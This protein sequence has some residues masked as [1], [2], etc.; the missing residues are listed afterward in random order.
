MIDGEDEPIEVPWNSKDWEQAIFQRRDIAIIG[1][2]RENVLYTPSRLV[3]DTRA[4]EDRRVSA[5]LERRSA[6][7]CRE[8]AAEVA[9]RLGLT[10]LTISDEEI[11]DAVRAIRRLAPGQASLDHIWLPGPNRV[12]GDDLPVPTDPVEIPGPDPS[13]GK[14]LSIFVLDTGIAPKVPFAVDARPED[15]EIPDE[16]GDNLRDFAAG[17]GTHISGLVAR[18]APAA[19]IAPRRLLTSPVGMASELDTAAAILAAG[20]DGADIINCSFGGTTLFDAPPLVT[21]R[22]LGSL[23][24]GTV[25]VAAAGNS[26]EERPHYPAAFKHVIAVGSVARVRGGPW[27]RADF[28][29]HGPW[30]DCCA[31]G[32]SV[33]ST[34]LDTDGLADNPPFRG[35]AT[36]SGTSFS[37]PQVAAAIAALATREGISPSLAAWRLVQDPARPRVGSVGTLVDPDDL[38]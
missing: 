35:W 28:S 30:V 33:P 17:H 6:K 16:D 26:G 24:P 27:Q 3:V 15:A 12:H 13:A 25:V 9:R 8:P 36:W 10:L 38:P 1:R 11:V 32:A 31:P 7:P 18:T 22:A 23:K 29:N 4:A 21:E 34:F 5:E 14:G 20:A 37:A 2:D 19:R